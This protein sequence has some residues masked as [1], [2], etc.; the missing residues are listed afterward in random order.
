VVRKGKTDKNGY[1]YI[2]GSKDISNFAAHKCN[3]VLDSAP[4]ELKPSNLHGGITGAVLK[5]KKSYV[6]KGHVLILYNVKPLAFEPKC[7]H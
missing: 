1:F 5:R 7:T 3:V 2:K 4:N 6:S